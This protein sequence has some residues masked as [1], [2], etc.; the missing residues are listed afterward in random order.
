[1]KKICSFLVLACAVAFLSSCKVN[2][3][4]GQSYDLPWYV[5]AL[6]VLA[7]FLITYLAMLSNTY[8]CPQCEKEFRPKW[9]QFSICMHFNGT[10]LARCP[11]CGK[12]SFCK[13]QR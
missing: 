13:I 4:G 3:F 5:I 8:I 1:M 10:R 11:H 7:I 12:R 6:F 2:G 9:H